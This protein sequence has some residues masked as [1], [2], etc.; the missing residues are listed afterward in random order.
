MR[1][2]FRA[3]GAIP[4]LFGVVLLHTTFLS[5]SAAE[6]SKGIDGVAYQRMAGKMNTLAAA[7]D[8]TGLTSHL[9]V[10]KSDSELDDPTREKLLR[11][12][13][14]VIAEFKPDASTRDS[15]RALNSYQSKAYIWRSEH[16]HREKELLYDVAAAAR[17]AEARWEENESFRSASIELTNDGHNIVDRY[18]RASSIEKRG[19]EEAFRTADT[20]SIERQR[21]MLIARLRSGEAVGPLSLVVARRLA[22]TELYAAVL[23]YA[24][25]ATALD[26]IAQLP[27]DST[28]L[29]SLSLLE[30]ATTRADIRSAA[31]L[32]IGRRVDRSPAAAD[33]LFAKLGTDGGASAATALARSADPASIDRLAEVLGSDAPEL[34][35]RHALLGLRLARTVQA[36]RHLAV[37]EADPDA[38]AVLVREVR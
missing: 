35:R 34:E 23:E 9:Q 22:D 19:I 7:A 29:N 24:D 36:E 28:E 25:S 26:A 4:L 38:P 32:A 13:L 14:L 33:A 15:V 5:V 12:T 1:M 11:E 6:T 18:T 20:S 27:L 37:F 16:G 3:P 8:V 17:F 30:T 10:L 21:G 31:L 2:K